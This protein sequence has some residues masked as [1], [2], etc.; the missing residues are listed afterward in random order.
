[1]FSSNEQFVGVRN[2]SVASLTVMIA[3]VL[4]EVMSSD[5][6]DFVDCV[7]NWV[8]L[9]KHLVGYLIAT[10]DYDDSLLS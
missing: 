7:Q 8:N 1:M 5:A 2:E 3:F 9:D 10:K 4:S 6:V